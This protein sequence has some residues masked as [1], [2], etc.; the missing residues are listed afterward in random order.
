MTVGRLNAPQEAAE[1]S[2][3][4]ARAM[5]EL[6]GKLADQIAAAASKGQDSTA[7]HR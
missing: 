2:P 7:A 5:S 3:G 4:Q 1:T 6:V